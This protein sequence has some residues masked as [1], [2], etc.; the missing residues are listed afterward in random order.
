MMS[1]LASLN[2]SNRAYPGPDTSG[3]LCSTRAAYY[4]AI[5]FRLSASL[6]CTGLALPLDAFIT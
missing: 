6:T 4:L 3:M 5:S 2:S 1:K